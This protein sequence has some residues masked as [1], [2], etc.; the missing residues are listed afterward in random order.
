[1]K[2]IVSPTDFSANAS[3][4]VHYAAALAAESGSYL[5]VVHA[6]E[7]PIMYSEAP[8]TSIGNA[9]N[10]L[11]ELAMDKLKKLVNKLS[12]AHPDLRCEAEVIEGLA[13]EKLT[14]FASKK[15]ADLMVVG[16]TGMSKLQRLLMGSTTARLIRDAHCP[17]LCVPKGATFK[18]MSKLVYATDLHEDNVSA[19]NGIIPFAK[20]FDA[21]IIFV[22]V[23]D[24][25]L[26]HDDEDVAKM[27]EKIRK[28]V[29]YP[30]ISGYISKNTSI[31][32][33][34]EY[35]LKKKPADLLVMFT[36]GRQFPDSMFN[37]SVTN[38]VS[39][40]TN[41]PLLTLKVPDRIM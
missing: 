38:V 2:L 26:L 19:A 21:E 12:K 20:H 5:L 4:A 32:K 8:L 37:Q 29:K 16:T 27:T 11:R 35:F 25:H 14:D 10:Q 36:H 33:G 22:F 23:D 18:S 39:H 1:M 6:Y 17:V 41:I 28:R 24:K 13:H 30:K 7:P 9:A 31:T 3:N 34:I 15:G 40:Q